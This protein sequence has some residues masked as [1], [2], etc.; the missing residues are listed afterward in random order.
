MVIRSHAVIQC[1]DDFGN[2]YGALKMSGAASGALSGGML[3]MQRETAREGQLAQFRANYKCCENGAWQQQ[4]EELASR[5]FSLYAL[6][7][8]YIHDLFEYMPDFDPQ[9]HRTADVVR[10]AIIPKSSGKR[11]AL[12]TILMNEE[13]TFPMKMVTHNWGNLFRDLVAAIVAD[14]LQEDEY[15]LLANL[16]DRDAQKVLDWVVKAGVG[17]HTYWVCA[18]SVSQH[19][20]ICHANPYFDMDPV[21]GVVHPVCTCGAYKFG[22]DTEPLYEGKSIPCEMNKFADMMEF[23]LKRNPEFEQVIAVDAQNQIWS[24]AWC[25]AEIARAHS[26]GMKQRMKLLNFMSLHDHEERLRNLKVEDM[27]ASRPEDVQQ[28]LDSIPDKKEFNRNLQT[29]IFDKLI[30]QWNDFDAADQMVVA[31][32]LIRWGNLAQQRSFHGI[33]EYRQNSGSWRPENLPGAHHQH[34]PKDAHHQH[35]P[36]VT[37]HKL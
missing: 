22:N 36:G 6:L 3:R 14:A 32:K 17:H 35:E 20:S 13:R 12:A 4:I 10:R 7:K 30:I 26:V 5:G 34:E 19:V 16:L 31:G 15:E 9:R 1:L 21:T 37:K 29:L 2:L 25:I 23:L 24:R 18:L 28:I 27:T 11:T 8:F 33:F